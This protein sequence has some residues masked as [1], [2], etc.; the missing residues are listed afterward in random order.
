MK[1]ILDV[2]HP[3][4]LRNGE[5]RI[6]A[7][8]SPEHTVIVIATQLPGFGVSITTAAET[9]ATEFWNRLDRPESFTWIEH[10]PAADGPRLTLPESFDRVFFSIST[11]EGLHQPAWQRISRKRVEALIQQPLTEDIASG[12]ST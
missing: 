7:Y 3:Y 1:L 4:M 10:Y 12:E 2:T 11:E 9:I 5:C 8:E 6:R